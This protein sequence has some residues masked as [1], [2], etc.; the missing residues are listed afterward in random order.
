MF[1]LKGDAYY[2]K[3]LLCGLK[4]LDPRGGWL[5][6]N[7]KTGWQIETPDLKQCRDI[8][9][10]DDLTYVDNKVIELEKY[11]DYYGDRVKEITFYTWH[12]G[13]GK[14][15]TGLNFKW[16]PYFLKNHH[17]DAKRHQKEIEGKFNF[18]NKT[19]KFLCLN[20][21]I[22]SHRD[23]V[24]NMIKDN[25]LCVSS[26]QQRN[27]RSPLESDWN[28]EEYRDWSKKSSKY[29]TNTMNLIVASPLYNATSFSL[30]TETRA[31]LPFDFI[32][33]KT[34]QCF[35]ALHPALYVSN[36]HHVVLLREWGFD[37]FDDIFDHSYD[38]AD[39]DKRINKLFSDN[40]SVIKNGLE[41]NSAIKSR[42]VKNREHYYKNFS[43]IVSL[44]HY[45]KKSQ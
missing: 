15:Y 21:R 20:A 38:D 14:I 3:N 35:L 1:T 32:T 43:A 23:K 9:L 41:I 13:L 28:F 25:P 4:Q 10:Q 11:I 18:A 31:N 37:L 24:F 40:E 34:T 16:Y 22:R 26:Y 36:K 27:I 39:D 8:F 2:H 30:V 5:G 6:H 42:L 29:L 17:E 12:K 19:S 33:E 45:H 44:E 7:P